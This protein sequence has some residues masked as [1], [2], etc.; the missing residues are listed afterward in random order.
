MKKINRQLSQLFK[1][2]LVDQKKYTAEN[3][4][5]N[6]KIIVCGA[7]NGFIAFNN[8]VLNRFNFTP[9]L[10]LDNNGKWVCRL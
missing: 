10:I 6:K 7:G 2:G 4:F 9:H 8:A 5:Q 1:D 3:I